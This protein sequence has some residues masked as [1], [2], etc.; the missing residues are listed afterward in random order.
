M[1]RGPAVLVA[2]LPLQALP[3]VPGWPFLGWGLAGL[4]LWLC[5]SDP[6]L[7]P[8]VRPAAAALATFASLGVLGLGVTIGTSGGPIATAGGDAAGMSALGLGLAL[9]ILA[10]P[11]LLLGFSGGPR[12]RRLAV[13]AVGLS[14]FLFVAP[15][16]TAILG[17]SRLEVGDLVT[18]TSMVTVLALVG[19]AALLLSLAWRTVKRRRAG[20]AA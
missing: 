19:Y 3:M 10:P 18:S 4:G 11:A 13:A 20:A 9:A 16:L 2:S 17:T 1:R 6:G 12:D 14:L 15:L 5:R 7:A 8:S